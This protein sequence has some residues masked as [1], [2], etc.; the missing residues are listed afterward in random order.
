MVCLGA[1]SVGSLPEKFLAA[2]ETV[3][4]DAPILPVEVQLA[5][6]SGLGV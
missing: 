3:P 1:G 5:V 6:G 2:L 4:A